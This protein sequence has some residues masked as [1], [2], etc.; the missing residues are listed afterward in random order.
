MNIRRWWCA[1]V[2]FVTRT[3]HPWRLVKGTAPEDWFAHP[4]GWWD[5]KNRYNLHAV[6][7]T[8]YEHDYCAR[9]GEVK[10]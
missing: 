6:M 4:F 9:C 7:E 8:K 3:D 5:F 2:R 1:V 10:E